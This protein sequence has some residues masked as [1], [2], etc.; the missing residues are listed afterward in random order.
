MKELNIEVILAPVGTGNMKPVVEQTFH[1]FQEILRGNLFQSGVIT[2]RH[3]SD[4]YD[5]A[6]LTIYD[7]RK[8]VYD[9]VKHHNMRLMEDY[10][11][12]CDMIENQ[13]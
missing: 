2:K 5:T 10:P 11:F 6:V 3:D 1:Q 4:H 8:I 7:I 9:Y 12:L 13:V